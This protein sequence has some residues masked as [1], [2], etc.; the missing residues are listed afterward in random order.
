M[1][2]FFSYMCFVLVLSG[3]SFLIVPP[4]KTPAQVQQPVAVMADDSTTCPVT[5]R[6]DPR[7]IPPSP[8]PEWPTLGEF[9]YG[10]AELWTAV[11]EDGEWRGLPHNEHGYTQKIFWWSKDYFWLDDP[12]PPLVVT[13]RRLDTDAP[14]LKVSP[15]TNAFADDIQSAMLVGVDFPTTGCWEITGR[16]QDAELSFVVWVAP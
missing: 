9:W 3:C 4:G 7:F 13:G 12:Q 8:F 5:K 10:A 16:Y 15:A 2:R 14:P 11:P 1:T 6:P